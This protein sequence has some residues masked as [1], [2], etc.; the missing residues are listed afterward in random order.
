MSS[1]AITVSLPIFN[2]ESF[3][4]ECIQSI[5]AQTFEDFE[6]IAV[7][8]GCTDRSEEIL[9]DL[10]DHRF[11]VI[12]KE[13]NE[14]QV[15]ACNQAIAEARAPVVARMDADDVMDV[16]RLERQHDFLLEH[17][18]VAVVGTYFDHIDQRGEQVRGAFPFPTTHE[19]IKEG[20]RVRVSVGH[21]TTAYRTAVVRSIGG[22]SPR[23]PV[24]L[25]TG[26]WLR[27]LAEGHRFANIPEVLH[28][29][30]EH[31]GQVTHRLRR[32][33]LQ[34]MNRAYRDYGPLIWGDDAPDVEFGAPLWRR[35][36]RRVRRVLRPK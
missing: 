4:A 3:L 21:P 27:L 15:P 12:K 14:G 13:R 9:M 16:R 6:V 22:Y 35:A 32:E 25:D 17:T 8:D 23:F 28:H 20:F 24:A 34:A 11:R 10:K 29:Y 31:G 19:G 18:E 30:R 5:L 33:Q 36:V 26:L 2:A 7:L 1:P